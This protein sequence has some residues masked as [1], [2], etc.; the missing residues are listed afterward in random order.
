MTLDDNIMMSVSNIRAV[1]LKKL[2]P[3]SVL[4]PCHDTNEYRDTGIVPA[5]VSGQVIKTLDL[6]DTSQR[7][8]ADLSISFR[9]G[10]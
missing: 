3:L 2:N 10:H 1:F 9:S 8:S 5:L 7:R 6:C 4:F